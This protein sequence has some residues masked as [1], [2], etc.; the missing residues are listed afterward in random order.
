MYISNI[1]IQNFRNFADLNVKF[2]EDINIIIGHNNVGKSNLIKAL[3]L[4][5]DSNARKQ[6]EIH[7]FNKYIALEDL[8]EQPSKITI[9]V[10]ISQSKDENLMS[11]DLATV[12]DWLI[13]LEEPYKALLTYEYFLPTKEHERYR[14]MVSEATKTEEI[15]RIIEDEFIRLYTYKI[16]GGNPINQ[17]VADGEW[18]Q[19][20]DFQFL[21]AIRDVERDMFTGRNTLL[22]NVLDFFMDYDIKSN[23]KPEEEKIQEIKDRKHEFTH[24]ANNLLDKLQNRMKEGQDE[25]LGYANNIGALFDKSSPGFEGNITDVELYSAL[26]LI[27]KYSEDVKIPVTHNGLGYNNLIFMSLLLSK[28]QVNADGDYLGSNVKIFPILAIEE[29]EAHLHPT[30]Q[31]QFLK[32]LS[33]NKG[34]NKVRQI[35]ITTHSTHIVASTSLDN[36]ICL[37]KD[38]NKISAGYPNMALDNEKSKKYVQRFLDATKSD[39]LFAEK[40]I[41]V[42]GLAEQLLLSIFAGYLGLSLEKNRITVINVGGRYFKHFLYLFDSRNP[43]AI[44]K[45]VACLID[46]DP[47]RKKKANGNSYEKCYPFEYNADHEEYE[48]QQNPFLEGYEGGGHPN[49]IFFTQD[50]KYGKTFEYDLILANPTSKL[51]LT[52]SISNKKELEVLMDLYENNKPLHE[53]TA[54]LGKSKENKRIIG[55]LENTLDK[56]DEDDK[57]KALIAARYLNSV[58]KGENALEL[59]Y[60]LQE[61]LEKKGTSEYQEF[62]VPDYIKDAIEWVCK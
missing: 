58:N 39:M 36:I 52:E 54:E 1:K 2:N 22:K 50:R 13:K 15:W 28:M 14:E 25:I 12:S 60:V 40:V 23:N 57:N 31:Y 17:S 61:N 24:D 16:W 19:K 49:I 47:S 59:A 8:K 20:F 46:I 7:D 27:V 10:T 42:E 18:L 11:D 44:N 53:L 32:F 21:D 29:P 6:L 26:K 45:K 30:M 41:L 9:S 34:S 35:F 5:F 43:N 51:L 62:K 56:W 33:E 55:S 38:N 4:I 37:Y 3:S 48:Y